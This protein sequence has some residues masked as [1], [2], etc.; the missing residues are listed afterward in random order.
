MAEAV[1]DTVINGLYTNAVFSQLM[2][3]NLDKQ[4]VWYDLVNHKY[5]E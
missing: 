2:R 3:R 1:K 5:E 4:S